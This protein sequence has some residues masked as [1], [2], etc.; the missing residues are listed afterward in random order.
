MR[1]SETRFG[2]IAVLPGPAQ[3]CRRLIPH[4]PDPKSLVATGLL[5]TSPSSSLSCNSTNISLVHPLNSSD[6]GQA[7][8]S[9]NGP[10]W[11]ASGA[12]TRPELRQHRR[13]ICSKRKGRV[14]PRR[15]CPF[16]H[17]HSAFGGGGCLFP[18]EPEQPLQSHPHPSG[19]L[20]PHWR[21]PC[22]R[23]SPH[24]HAPP[25]LPWTPSIS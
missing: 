24:P 16:I 7:A 18:R 13:E 8:G 4:R 12:L 23:P 20:G 17:L 5:L 9:W 3:H 11:A 1:H 6:R 22:Q 25:G 19:G 21:L 14:S 10:S 15:H 2:A